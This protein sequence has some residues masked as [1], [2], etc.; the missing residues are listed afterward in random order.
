MVDL[1]M[2]KDWQTI[3]MFRAKFEERLRQYYFVGGMPAVVAAFAEDGNWKE[4]EPY[5]TEYWI[6]TSATSRSMLR[7]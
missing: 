5:R 3:T 7:Q 2:S 1:L 6:R 4:C